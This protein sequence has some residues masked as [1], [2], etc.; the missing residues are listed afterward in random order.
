MP[1]FTTPTQTATPLKVWTS[2]V[3]RS[4]PQTENKD[5]EFWWNL[6]GYHL[7][8][9]IDAA[10][11]SIEKQYEVLLFHYHWIVSPHPDMPL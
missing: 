7:A 9:M 4:L 10:G 6:T 2:L 11:Y 3:K 5:V 1:S 8:V